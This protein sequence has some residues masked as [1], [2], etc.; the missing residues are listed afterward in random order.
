MVRFDGSPIYPPRFSET[1]SYELTP[2]ERELYEAATEYVRLHY[3][4]ARILNR[5]A[6]RLAMS[7]LQ[8]RAASCTYSLLRSLER[9]RERLQGFIDAL[10]ADEMSESTFQARQQAMHLEDTESE[11]TGEEEQGEEGREEQEVTEDDAMGATSSGSLPDLQTELEKVEA[12]VVKAQRVYD[13][14]EEAKF[15]RL[16]GVINDPSFT[17]EKLLIFT[18]HVDTLRYLQGQLEALGYTGQAAA[19]TD[20]A[21]VVISLLATDPQKSDQLGKEIVQELYNV[22]RR[23]AE[24][25]IQPVEK[26]DVAEVLRRRFFTPESIAKREGFR[27][28]VVSA[29]EGIQALD[30][31]TRKGRQTEEERYQNPPSDKKFFQFRRYSGDPA[32]ENDSLSAQEGVFSR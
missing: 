9:R 13:L 19:K 4:K 18:E 15:A 7:V 1:A 22:V 32:S 12:L 11:K 23:Q 20:H 25:G 3:N 24:Q 31:Q 17:N 2:L 27:A 10:L 5:S 29:L 28:N 26:Q 14:G 30:E 8:R 16:Q 6:A 21:C